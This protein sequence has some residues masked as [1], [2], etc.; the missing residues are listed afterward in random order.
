MGLRYSKVV[1][2]VLQLFSLALSHS[3]KPVEDF[4]GGVNP[5]SAVSNGAPLGCKMSCPQTTYTGF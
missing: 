1:L 4:Y 2:N 3:F 5:T